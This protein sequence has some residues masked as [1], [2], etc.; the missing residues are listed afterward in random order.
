MKLRKLV[1]EV[2]SPDVSRV[3]EALYKIISALPLADPDLQ[4]RVTLNP[5][6]EE[7]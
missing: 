7:E 5:V 2:T 3:A 6:Q 1:V 4:V